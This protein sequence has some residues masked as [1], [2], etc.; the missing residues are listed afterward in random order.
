MNSLQSATQKIP[1]LIWQTSKS[2]PPQQAYPLIKSWIDLNPEYEWLFMDDD[3][4]SKFIEDNFSTEFHTMYKSLPYGVMRADVWRVAVVY[5]YGGIYVDTDCRCITPISTWLNPTDELIVG[6]E[7]E[8]GDLLNFA[9]ASTPKNPALLSVLN[10]FYEL[11]NSPNFMSK[12]SSSPIQNFGQYGFSDGILR[13]FS[14]NN[15]ESMNL[16]GATNYYNENKLVKDSNT[17]FILQQEKRFTNHIYK[18]SYIFHEVAS[19]KW[20]SGYSSWRKDQ[21]TFLNEKN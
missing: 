5:V 4:C 18:S 12:D 2:N 1:K 11:Y 10:R 13:H 9:F 19:F 16:G 8:G 15:R 21:R 20:R 17:K 6:V 14:M 7:V 3:R